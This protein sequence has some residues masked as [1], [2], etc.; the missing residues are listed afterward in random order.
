MARSIHHA[1][2]LIKQRHIRVGKHVVNVASF[3]VRPDI[4][5]KHIYSAL[6]S[7]FD[8]GRPGRVKRKNMKDASKK[9]VRGEEEEN[10]D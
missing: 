8:G 5:Q 9:A 6:S 4:S 7:A 1:G 10:E 2:V 3:L